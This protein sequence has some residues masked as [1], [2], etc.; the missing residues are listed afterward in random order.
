MHTDVVTQ[1]EQ[2]A[3]HDIHYIQ[4]NLFGPRSAKLRS[5]THD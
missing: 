1:G 2:H 4:N 5:A 3:R